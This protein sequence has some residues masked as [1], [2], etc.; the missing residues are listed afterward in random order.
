[1]DAHECRSVSDN[2]SGRQNKPAANATKQKHGDSCGLK[3]LQ[4]GFNQSMAGQSQTRQAWG[5]PVV[6]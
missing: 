2:I 3:G 1:M 6:G 4:K 5:T